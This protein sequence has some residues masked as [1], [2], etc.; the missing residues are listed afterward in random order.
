[1]AGAIGPDG[2]GVNYTVD[3]DTLG[4]SAVR[5]NLD[6]AALVT[7]AAAAV[8]ANSADQS[9]TVFRG[10]KIVA[11]I[12]AITGTAPTLVVTLQ[13]K[14]AVSGKYYTI[15]ASAAIVAISTVVLT[16]YP[17][18]LAAANVTANDILPK[19]WRIITVVGGTTPAVTATVSASL[20]L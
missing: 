13:G 18:L 14:D 17:G 1:M 16:V 10:L 8:G 4:N 9:N 7:L 5:T 19:G 6:T 15:L 3:L 20:I 2:M 11:D 12:T